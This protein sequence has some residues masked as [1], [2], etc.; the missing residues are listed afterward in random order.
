MATH[1]ELGAASDA[2]IPRLEFAEERVAN[3]L[4]FGP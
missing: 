2:A 3:V 1:T 4:S